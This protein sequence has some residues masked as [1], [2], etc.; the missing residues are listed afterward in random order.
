MQNVVHKHNIFIATSLMLYCMKN[1]VVMVYTQNI[2]KND[3]NEKKKMYNT[4]LN[5][6][7]TCNQVKKRKRQNIM[8][9]TM[10]RK[11]K[12]LYSTSVSLEMMNKKKKT[13]K[14]RKN[15]NSNHDS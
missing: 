4:N 13:K 12:H 3:E 1:R 6:F 2:R 8:R 10:V 7:T 15:V 9:N 11:N 5:K 14:N